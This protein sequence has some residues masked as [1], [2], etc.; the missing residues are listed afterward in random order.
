[1]S[2]NFAYLNTRDFEFIAQE[3]LPTEQVFA[4]K[5]FVDYYSKDDV[6]S[7]RTLPEDGQRGYRTHQ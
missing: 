7:I 3:W 6:K 2:A 4:Y 1:M 5:E